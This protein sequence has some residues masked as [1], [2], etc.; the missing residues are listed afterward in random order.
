MKTSIRN[1]DTITGRIIKSIDRKCNYCLE[2]KFKS[3]F[4]NDKRMR[5]CNNCITKPEVIEDLKSKKS[6][7]D[8]KSSLKRDFKI[9]E[10]IYNQMLLD[11]QYLCKICDLH[12]SQVPTSMKHFHVDHCHKT[13]KVRGLLCGSCNQSLGL[14]KENIPNMLQACRYLLNNKFN[15]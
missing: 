13:G 11:Q 14:F 15:K 2:I 12:V 4:N 3:E 7:S 6:Y 5:C 9:T 8:W 10:K 1:R